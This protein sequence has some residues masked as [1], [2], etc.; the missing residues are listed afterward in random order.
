MFEGP[1]T[2]T[3]P[4]STSPETVAL[5][6]DSGELTLVGGSGPHE[7]NIFVGGKPV[8]DDH[9]DAT[10][11][12]VVCRFAQNI[13]L[14]KTQ[15]THFAQDAGVP[16][17]AA[18]HEVSVWISPKHLRHGRCALHGQRNISPWLP[19]PHCGQLWFPWGSRSHLLWLV[20]FKSHLVG[21]LVHQ[22]F[23]LH[24]SWLVTID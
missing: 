21:W 9:H 19:S 6:I 2:P 13:K 8:C 18:H 10:N 7:G 23:Q 22:S 3:T 14:I 4:I 17:W 15:L 11:A 16:I 24:F 20:T 12:L 1:T 5:R